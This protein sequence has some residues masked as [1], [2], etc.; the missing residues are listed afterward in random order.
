VTP[1]SALVAARNP[2]G[3]WPYYP[4]KTSR[5][6]PTAWALLAL[7]A[8]GGRVSI[9][10]LLAWPRRDAWLLDRSSG[11]IN[12]GFNG[13]AAIVLQALG[14][15]A[16]ILAPLG[17]AL[18]A[19]KGRKLPASPANRQDNSLQGWAWTD[20]TF[21]WVEPTAWGL[22]ALKRLGRRGE[23][24]AAARIDEA[25]RLLT[26][27]VCQ[28]GG[29]NFGNADV[30]GTPLEPYVSS[31]ALG[32]LAMADRRS[33][34]AVARSFRYLTTHRLSERSAM[35]LGLSRV[36]L[37]VYGAA[38]DD[39]GAAIDEQWKQ[40][41]FLDNLHVTALALYAQSASARGFEAFRV[42]PG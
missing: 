18:V 25:E 5:L 6:E 12:V 11:A 41:A 42:N 38:A 20:G 31:T 24:A 21:S 36:A 32:L 16:D 7:H 28:A 39:V 9:D 14:A 3:G 22:I 40:T 29:W 8:S 33:I 26:D 30:L 27:R 13:L 4:G 34:E 15:P 17:K 37:G 23:A 1:K 35:A 19:M 2:D 10:P